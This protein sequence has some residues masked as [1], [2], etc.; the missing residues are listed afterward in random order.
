MFLKESEIEAWLKSRI[1]KL[2]GM[3]LKFTSPGNDGVPDRIVIMPAGICVFLELKTR[4]GK[5]SEIQKYQIRKLLDCCQQVAVVYGPDAAEDFL[6]DL[7]RHVVSSVAYY[8]GRRERLPGVRDMSCREERPC[9][10]EILFYEATGKQ[11]DCEK[12]PMRKEVIDHDLQT[13]RVPGPDDQQ[14]H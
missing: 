13:A 2:G 3:F 6:K 5:L 12:C 10:V 11:A 1:E 9:L 7:Q 8:G 14:D 4:K